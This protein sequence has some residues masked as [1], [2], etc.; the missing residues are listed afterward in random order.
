MTQARPLVPSRFV[1]PSIPRPGGGRER[2]GLVR[3]SYE[4]IAE[5]SRS[6]ALAK[7]LYD[8]GLIDGAEWR[9]KKRELLREL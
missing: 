6:F 1:R 7:Q 5:G 8:R 2:H 3:E 9:A 4:M